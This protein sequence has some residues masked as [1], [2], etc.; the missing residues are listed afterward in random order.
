M[1]PGRSRRERKK[2]E[3]AEATA[4]AVAAGERPR[5]LLRA[6]RVLEKAAKDPEAFGAQSGTLAARTRSIVKAAGLDPA[7]VGGFEGR[8]SGD[9]GDGGDGGEGG[10]GGGRGV[11]S[12]TPPHFSKTRFFSHSSSHLCFHHSS[13]LSIALGHG[14]DFEKTHALFTCASSVNSCAAFTLSGE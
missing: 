8:E 3:A 1:V 12:H 2:R 5:D 7:S 13:P 14:S 6:V 11:D 9:G 10:G 4:A